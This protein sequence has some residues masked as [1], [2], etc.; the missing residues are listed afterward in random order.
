MSFI[1]IE[2]KNREDGFS[3][4]TPQS[5]KY[6]EIYCLISG[7]ARFFVDGKIFNIT[8]GAIII[9]PPFMMH[10]SL[11]GVYERVNIYVSPDILDFSEKKLLDG[12][13]GFPTRPNGEGCEGAIYALLSEMRAG[14][15]DRT[16]GKYS[17]HLAKSFVFLLGGAGVSVEDSH[18]EPVRDGEEM[19]GIASYI[20]SSFREKITISSLCERFFMSKNTLTKKFQSVMHCSVTEY[21]LGVRLSRAKDLLTEGRKSMSDIAAECGFSSA[22]YFSLIFTRKVGISPKNY[23]KRD[24]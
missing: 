1:E 10:R 8:E 23:R 17:L 7:S 12:Y 2:Y 24:G 13:A 20:N 15:C 22:N 21:L 16:L 4:A 18:D 14:Y 11:G 5:H 3:M 9:I 6:Y 19:L